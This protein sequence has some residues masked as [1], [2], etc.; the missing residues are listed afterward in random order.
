M[1]DNEILLVGWCNS[2]N[3]GTNLQAIALYNV[4]NRFGKCDLFWER[5][6]YTTSIFW[7]KVQG[8]I[9]S[10]QKK[11]ERNA[12]SNNRLKLENISACYNGC[13]KVTINSKNELR[14]V[15]GKYSTFVVGSDQVWNPYYLND[16][17]LLD[18][19]PGEK[20][21]IS[22]AASMG[23][24]SIPKRLQGKYRKYLR[25]FSYISMR[26]KGGAEYIGDLIGKKVDT[27]LDPTLLL[28]KEEWLHY[29]N[30]ANLSIKLPSNFILCYFVGADISYWSEVQAISK[31]M[32]LPIVVVPMNAWDLEVSGAII[33][34]EA[35][36]K[37]FIM[38]LELATVVCTDSFHMCAF[39]LNFN[40]NLIAF[41]RFSDSDSAGQ[42]SRIDDLFKMLGVNR[43]YRDGIMEKKE[44]FQSC[45]VRLSAER[46]RCLSSLK[47]HL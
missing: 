4:L 34:S 14:G 25:D 10:F 43:Y 21:K 12:I 30:D 39:S 22:Y 16:T 28:S 35:G 46:K 20:T 1:G 5:R 29:C 24:S 8:K 6:Y 13:N 33:L 32:A 7:E 3:F 40:K 41:K 18:F 17:F 9:K 45:N 27:V 23:V 15:I 11:E 42:N 36:P 26:E 19:V 38:A 2:T 47:D 44:D 37:E 31:Q